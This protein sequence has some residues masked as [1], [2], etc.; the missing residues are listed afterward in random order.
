[1]AA[2]QARQTTPPPGRL[3]PAS[4]AVSAWSLGYALYRGYYALGGTEWLPGQP[5]D[6]AQFRLINGVAVVILLVAAATPLALLAFWG[7]RRFRPVA[8]TLC[9]TVAVGC[10][11]HALINVVQRIL[12]LAGRLNIDY[13][14]S[15]WASINR[16]EADL[17]DVLFNEPWFLL[18]G[19]GFAVL[20]WIVLGPGRARRRWVGGAA[21]AILALTGIGLLSAFGVIGEVIVG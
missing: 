3:V 14:E 12:S 1:M 7:H 19:L 18:E 5:A 15:F 11:S 10:I 2:A 20:A 21:A 17:Q 8:L 9:W 4:V 6:P 16:R 13:P